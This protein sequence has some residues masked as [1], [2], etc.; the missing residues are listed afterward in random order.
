VRSLVEKEAALRLRGG[1][2]TDRAPLLDHDDFLSGA[3]GEG[4]RREPGKA[5]ADH[6][7]VEILGLLAHDVTSDTL[8]ERAAQKVTS[9]ERSTG[10]RNSTRSLR[11]PWAGL[12]LVACFRLFDGMRL[13]E[14]RVALGQLDQF[15]EVQVERV[16]LQGD[17]RR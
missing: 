11:Q 7:D 3:R 13:G 14:R 10:P 6:C 1:A 17:F 8:H 5:P 12:K 4:R 2:A 16:R 15:F 9:C